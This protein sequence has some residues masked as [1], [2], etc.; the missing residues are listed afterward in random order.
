MLVLCSRLNRIVQILKVSSFTGI[1]VAWW[2]T[3]FELTVSLSCCEWC[4]HK[5]IK[6]KCEILEVALG[7]GIKV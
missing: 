6:E 1:C 5:V 3:C 4:S 2:Y 7:K